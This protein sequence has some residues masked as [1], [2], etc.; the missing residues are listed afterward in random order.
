MVLSL[1]IMKKQVKYETKITFILEL[2]EIKIM[3]IHL[4][5][6]RLI[7]MKKIQNSDESNQWSK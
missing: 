1:Y 3:G 6:I 2:K 5:K 4:K 7:Y